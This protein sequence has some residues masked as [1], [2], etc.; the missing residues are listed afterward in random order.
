VPHP[1]APRYL[2]AFDALVLPSETQPN[3]KEQFG[4]VVVEAL[5]SETP[6][7]GTD[8]GEIPHL[9]RRTG[10][11]LVVPERAPAALADA[12]AELA[13]R[14]DRR[15]TLARRGAEYVRT[16]LT[17]AALAHTFASTVERAVHAPAAARP[18]S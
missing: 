4:R 1:E 6:V 3:W 8:S 9:L 18:H 14:P 13:V 12:L 16:H 7:V 17:H 11:G 5:A 2:S 10:G 15:A